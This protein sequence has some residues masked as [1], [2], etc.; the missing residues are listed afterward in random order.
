MRKENKMLAV[1]GGVIVCVLYCVVT[2]LGFKEKEV[3]FWIAFGFSMIAFLNQ[4]LLL[5]FSMQSESDKKN[6]FL[7]LSLWM[8]SAIY[9]LA[10][11]VVSLL[12]M[13][14][15][16]FSQTFVVI[17]EVILVGLF[18]IFIISGFIGKKEIS[19]NEKKIKVKTANM[20]MLYSDIYSCELNAEDSNLKGE[21]HKLAEEIRYSDPMSN[22]L[23][24][25]L[26]GQLME[27]ALQIKSSIQEKRGEQATELVRKMELLLKERNQKIVMLK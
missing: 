25:G 7:G 10:Q 17:M 13:G 26:E 5:G 8:I 4:L 15:S 12:F 20:E 23:L 9:L 14:I 3:N 27:C 19:E 24:A 22:D 21:L 16:V 2:L 18:Y 6:G 1:V 11:L